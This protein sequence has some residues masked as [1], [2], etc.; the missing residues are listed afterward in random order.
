MTARVAEP[1]TEPVN[2]KSTTDAAPASASPVRRAPPLAPM[3]RALPPPA[4][5]AA[6]ASPVPDVHISIGSVEIRANTA[7]A[8]AKPVAPQPR[9]LRPSMNL[10]DY[11]HKRRGGR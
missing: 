2:R 4:I 8:R 9:A 7:P 10:T 5:K 3:T 11:L 6:P 1:A